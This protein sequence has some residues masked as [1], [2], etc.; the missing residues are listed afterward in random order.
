MKV[1]ITGHRG[2]VGRHFMAALA[3][4]E[5][6]GVD[7]ADGLDA[8]DFFR[9]HQARVDLVIH[10]AAVVG[11]RAK[12]EGAPLDLAVDLALDAE[13][14]SWA[15]RT[16]PGK[17]VY[18]SSSAAYPAALQARAEQRIDLAEDMI[19]LDTVATPDHLYGWAKLTGEIL[20]RHARAAGLDV[21][22]VRPFSGY[23]ED[24]ALDYPFP[25]FIDRAARRCDPFEI[26]GDG[27]QTRDF[28][29]IHDV[30][31]A[32]LRAVE[33]GIDGPVNL[34]TGVATSFNEL[35]RMVCVAAGY[36]P[37]FAHRPAAPTGVWHRVADPSQMLDFYT[38]TISIEQ[39]VARA[40]AAVTVAA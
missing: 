39:G 14:F 15:L 31:A 6:F 35:A 3:G 23:G 5:V 13:M 8:R 36:Q 24:Q 9:R 22:V 18:F 40:L 19:D 7:I 32:T 26:W 20:A 1:L 28:I 12:I 37:E 27:T 38:P 16:R 33:L 17:V 4:H 29:H 34:G 25:S 2:F 21:L 11:G 10:L 30:V